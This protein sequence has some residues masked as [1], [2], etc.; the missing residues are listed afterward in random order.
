[1]DPATMRV[2]GSWALADGHGGV[3]EPSAIAVFDGRV[4]VADAV[5]D[6]VTAIDP[7]TGRELGRAV[8]LPGPIRQ[9]VVGD[10]ALWSATS[11]PGAVVR[12]DPS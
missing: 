9:L 12:I 8:A 7:V 5:H 6:T 10:G 11:Y 3:I 1:V 2:T 4:W